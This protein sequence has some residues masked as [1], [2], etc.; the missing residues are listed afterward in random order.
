MRT[1]VIT[2]VCLFAFG[3]QCGGVDY[4]VNGPGSAGGGAGSTGGGAGGGA[5]GG[6][7]QTTAPFPKANACKVMTSQASLGSKPVDIIMLIDNSGSMTSEIQ[8][9]E[10]NVNT[11]FAQIIEASGLDYRVILI[12]KHGTA[13]A[14]QS[15][16]I[17]APLSGT[18]CNP[19]PTT[20]VN[21]ARFF[22]YDVEISSTNSLTKLLQTYD[23]TDV[24]GFAPGGWKGWLR[25]DSMKTI[26]EITDD[27]SSITAD[28]FEQQLFQKAGADFG[29][30]SSRRYIFH[31]IIGITPSSPATAAW[32]PNQPKVGQKCSSAA[33]PGARYEDLS[34]RT[35][36]L[37]FPVCETQ[38]YDAVFQAAAQGVI[39]SAQLSCDFLPPTPPS[40]QS[41]SDAYVAYTPG[42]GGAVEYLL[43]KDAAG[44]CAAD[45]FQMDPATARITLCADACARVK[46]DP[47]AKLEVV[48]ACGSIIQ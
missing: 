26:I 18:T 10:E 7:S 23:L 45:K 11:H 35:G 37:R 19:V 39:A 30:A 29:S 6:S 3:C 34:L 28:S 27:E 22:H 33:N 36:G 1:L 12:A 17:K 4:D 20:P 2:A 46:A 41:Y 31:S 16:C 15:V 43:A 42:N 47:E 8:A 5:G 44:P 24:N 40:G 38:S 25:A 14:D 48:Y 9:V 13:S 32:Q 21:G